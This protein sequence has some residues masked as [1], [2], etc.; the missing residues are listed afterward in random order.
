MKN[1]KELKIS[2]DDLGP[3]KHLIAIFELE[4]LWSPLKTLTLTLGENSTHPVEILEFI[5]KFKNLEFLIFKENE[6]ISDP[7]RFVE[8]LNA[9]PL[10]KLKIGC[11]EWRLRN[12]KAFEIVSK[13]NNLEKCS[14]V[15]DKE[16]FDGLEEVLS[17]DQPRFINLKIMTVSIKKYTPSTDDLCRLCGLFKDCYALN[18]YVDIPHYKFNEMEKIL[19]RNV[20]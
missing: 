12:S 15:F 6:H 4:N 2:T 5:K 13:I 20:P 11:F 10:N 16:T 19:I 14:M 18:V 17:Q 9:I 1:L 7:N 3:G 8:S